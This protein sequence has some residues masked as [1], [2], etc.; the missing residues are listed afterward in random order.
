MS[1][2]VAAGKDGYNVV[3][4]LFTWPL[5]SR[6]L[7]Y[8]G[9]IGTPR[10]RE[11]WINYTF[12]EPIRDR[13][14]GVRDDCGVNETERRGKAQ[15]ARRLIEL[16]SREEACSTFKMSVSS[17]ALFGSS[18]LSCRVAN[19][20]IFFSSPSAPFALALFAAFSE[21]ERA[22]FAGAIQTTMPRSSPRSASTTTKDPTVMPCGALSLNV[23]YRWLHLN[24]T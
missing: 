22:E 9:R 1:S 10:L 8:V 13:S 12:L 5:S 21:I 7:I 24:W 4:Y 11:V 2:E 18:A 19:L 16:F 15:A 3:R 23:M 6:G 20:K 17:F 14:I